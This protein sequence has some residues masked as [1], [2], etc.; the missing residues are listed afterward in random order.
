MCI[1][2]RTLQYLQY[3]CQN[4]LEGSPHSVIISEL[5]PSFLLVISRASS[6][7]NHFTSAFYLQLVVIIH[8]FTT[9]S[10]VMCLNNG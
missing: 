8:Y 10:A 2:V 7:F 6:L 3:H 4:P 1:F 9:D 5:S